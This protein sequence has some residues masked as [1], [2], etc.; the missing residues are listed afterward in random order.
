MGTLASNR[1]GFI[2]GAS[3]ANYTAALNVTTGTASDSNSTST[4]G[5]QYF[6]SSGRGGGTFRFIRTFLRVISVLFCPETY[7]FLVSL[8]NSRTFLNRFTLGP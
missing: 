5:V 4:V 7:L 6:Q 1:K 2:T 3:A 8:T